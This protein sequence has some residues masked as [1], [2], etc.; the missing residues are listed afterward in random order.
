MDFLL[1]NET[2]PGGKNG[3]ARLHYYTSLEIFMGNRRRG[4]ESLLEGFPPPTERRPSKNRRDE[5]NQDLNSEHDSRKFRNQN[6]HD[7]ASD[8]RDYRNKYTR[9]RAIAVTFEFPPTAIGFAISSR[10]FT[11]VPANDGHQPKTISE[12]ERESAE[13]DSA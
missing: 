1:A 10:L 5:Q 9:Y 7:A 6:I 8:T 3:A 4:Q 13:N 11:E 12:P 2:P